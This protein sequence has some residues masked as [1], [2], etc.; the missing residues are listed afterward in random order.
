MSVYSE[1][2]TLDGSMSS[3]SLSVKSDDGYLFENS[4]SSEAHSS[5]QKHMKPGITRHSKIN[6]FYDEQQSF[7]RDVQVE[8]ALALIVDGITA[9]NKEVSVTD[10]CK[11]R[12]TLN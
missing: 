8:T 5:N 10:I 4:I 3:P 1:N 12:A 2:S 11:D 9:M 6:H 7:Q